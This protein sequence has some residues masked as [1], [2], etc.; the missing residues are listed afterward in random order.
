VL[1]WALLVLPGLIWRASFLFI[2]ES[3]EALAP[4][5]VA[6]ARLAIGFL[7]L[8]LVPGARRPCWRATASASHDLA[9]CGWR[10]R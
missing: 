2:A 8:S 5:G 7:T 1:D 4:D 10:F 6:F 3:L 9:R